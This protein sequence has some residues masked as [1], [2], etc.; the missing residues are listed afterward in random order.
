MGWIDGKILRDFP[1]LRAADASLKITVV[2]FDRTGA[3][4]KSSPRYQIKK[5]TRDEGGG[6]VRSGC[7][8]DYG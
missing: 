8:L 2:I 3:R 7:G 5:A 1:T 6:R 4:T